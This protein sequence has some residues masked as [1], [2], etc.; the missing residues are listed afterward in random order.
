MGTGFNEYELVLILRNLFQLGVALGFLLPPMLVR[1]G[2]LDEI[3]KDLSIMFYG[4][5]AVTAGLLLLVILCKNFPMYV[6]V[7]GLGYDFFHWNLHVFL[8]LLSF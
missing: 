8:H 5:G 6:C 3:G 2:T 7:S 1:N 4:T